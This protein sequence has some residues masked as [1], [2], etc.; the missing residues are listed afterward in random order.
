MRERHDKPSVCFSST[1]WD[2]TDRH[3]DPLWILDLTSGNSIRRYPCECAYNESMVP[4]KAHNTFDRSRS[5]HIFSQVG[6][7]FPRDDESGRGGTI[8]QADE[9]SESKRRSFYRDDG[10]KMEA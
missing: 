6:E 7:V 8:S 10:W 5:D 2:M 4:N 9:T 3:P 1:L